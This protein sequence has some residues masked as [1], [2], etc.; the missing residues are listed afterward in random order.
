VPNED[1]GTISQYKT[2][3]DGTLAQN[4][5]ATFNLP[6]GAQL[7]QVVVNK[8]GNFAYATDANLHVVYQLKI[9][10][11]G[12]LA[13]NSPSSVP[14]ATSASLMTLDGG[15]KFAYVDDFGSLLYQFKVNSNGT[16][17]PIPNSSNSI[18]AGVFNAQILLV[19]GGR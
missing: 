15:G 1:D 16:L 18:A 8:K 6:T 4:S 14:I 2:N 10:H 3:P 17:S 9:N 12:T 7:E 19:P 5:P 13:M 11:D